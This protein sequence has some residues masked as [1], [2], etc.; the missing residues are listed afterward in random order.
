MSK[1]NRSKS[2]G[3][4]L[5]V[6]LICSG[7]AQ[8]QT[9]PQP[10]VSITISQ[11]RGVDARVDY[12]DLAKYGPWD[13]RNYLLTK[14]DVDLLSKNESDAII[15]IPVFYR[16]EMR[17]ANPGLMISGPAQYPRSALN[18][19]L[20][21]YEGFKINGTIYTSVRANGTG[22]YELTQSTRP[23]DQVMP[24]FL[25]GSEKRM[26]TPAGGAESAV[27]INP[28]NTNLVIAGTNGPGSGQKMWQ[29]TDGGVTWGSAISLAN[30]C[31]DPTVGW[32][33]DGSIGYAGALSTVVGSG[34]NVLFYRSTNNGASWTLAKTLSTG[35]VSDKE[36]LH[37]DT[38]ASSPRLG[39]IYMA[40]HEN[41][42]QKFA[43]STDTG[44]NWG[45]T[46]TLDSASRGIGSDLMSDKAGNAY[47]VFP[48]TSG[49]SNAK[50][51]RVL[52]STDGGATFAAAVNASN[53]NADF[54]YPIPAMETRRAFVYVS[55]Q[56]DT[57]S[58]TFAN[59]LYITYN[60]T[61]TT[62]NNT[63][64]TAN[65]SV[66]KVL[67][68]RD[69]GATWASSLAHSSADIATVDRF[70]PW[71]SVDQTGRVFVMFYDTRNSTSRSG[72][73]I[74][75]SVSTDGGV[76]F[77][78]ATR[79]TA[80]TS[81][82]IGDSFEWGDYNGMD[83][84]LNDIMAIYTDNRDETGGTAESVDAYVKGGFSGV[85]GNVAPSANYS[86]TTS[87]L[88]ANF[89]DSSTDS[90]GTIASRSWNFGDS[91]TSTSTNPS[92]TYS[93]A[94]SY[95]V[96]LTV[97]DNGGLTNSITRSVT[98][99]TAANVAPVA[100][101]S[102]STS[103]LTATF[104]DSSTDSDGT[105]ASRSWNFG[106]STTSTA[107]NPSKTYS[108][109]GTFNV[110]LTVTD[111]G[112]ATNSITRAVTVS[113]SGTELSNGVAKTG[114]SAALGTSLNFTMAV[115][116][117]ATG[118]KFVI[119]GGTGDADMYV[120]FGSAPTD[121]VYDCRPFLGGNAETCNIATAV[122]GTYHVR[123]KAYSAFSGVSLTGSYSVGGAFFQNLTDVAIGDNTTV[124]SPITVTGVAGNAP[125]TLSVA[126]NIVHTY[127]GDL[128]VDLVAPDGTLY[129]IHNR[130][131]A[132]TDNIIKTVTINASSEVANG[133]WNLRVN[134][135]AGGDTGFINSWSMQF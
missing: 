127:Q 62:E 124:N 28:V 112:G 23:S 1:H 126:V 100:N 41:N 49:G 47:F 117:G 65:H 105:I 58:G 27:A 25:S 111:N 4:G 90:D 26:S 50:Q 67:R 95:S 76:T 69:G 60:D 51:I 37:V 43:R 87:G 14:A 6:A 116:T 22:G 93:A 5:A 33:P 57:S 96:V 39:S 135:N 102:F 130:T 38:Y 24:N 71:M 134:D 121:T 75:Y 48:T 79:L 59:S 55:A 120:K 86:F 83:M 54:D 63:S 44:L 88:T 74:Y 101:Y 94:G 107:T 118:L 9:R 125:A 82:N 21:K 46:L 104:T 34:T 123:L 2:V 132:G 91:T 99:S 122:A 7:I 92:K 30:T 18:G 68:S 16:V 36:Y 13:D 97:T 40:W 84:Q 56:A 119:S 73:D 115:P 103:G 85:V 72:T 12:A 31:C 110:V 128:K 78:T 52:K 133:T 15:P 70:N 32:S 20:A 17:K 8:A 131:G 108:A 10:P 113:T 89:T 42:V 109:A 77:S 45:T 19:Y 61:N 106:D 3:L 11:S 35:N 66:V 98:V 53:L 80:V 64:A 29:S 129:N 81:K 114:L